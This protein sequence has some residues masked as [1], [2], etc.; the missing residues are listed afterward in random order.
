[1]Y[2]VIFIV[3]VLEVNI[4]KFKIDI[5]IIKINKVFGFDGIF[6]CSLV[7]VGIFVL[8]GIVIV[9]KSSMIQFSFFNI[10]KIVKVNVIFKKGNLID[11]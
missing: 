10:W 4:N 8:E 3:Q 7:I 5:K 9:F 1:M 11:L 6:F 2:R